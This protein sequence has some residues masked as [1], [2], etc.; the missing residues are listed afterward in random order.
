[1]SNISVTSYFHSNFKNILKKKKHYDRRII[2]EE[3][4]EMEPYFFQDGA[5]KRKYK[6]IKRLGSKLFGKV[7][8][9]EDQSDFQ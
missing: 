1:M 8:L 6:L 2:Q 5:S 7:Y 3:L 9:V 4:E